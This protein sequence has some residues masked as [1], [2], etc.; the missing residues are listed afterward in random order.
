PTKKNTSGFDIPI[1]VDA[2]VFPRLV[3]PTTEKFDLV[4]ERVAG[5]YG[6]SGRRFQRFRLRYSL[7]VVAVYTLVSR[8]DPGEGVSGRM[9]RGM[10][11]TGPFL[12]M[13]VL[14]LA[15]R[16]HLGMLE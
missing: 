6:N 10:S 4:L 7:Q 8:Q 11:V 12:A 16:G 14:C 3:S 5:L 13:T 1:T 2:V 15:P 9:E